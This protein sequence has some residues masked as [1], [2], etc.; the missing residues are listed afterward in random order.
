MDIEFESART[1]YVWHALKATDNERKHGVEFFE[2]VTVF[3][4]PLLVSV[5]ASIEIEVRN[6]AIGFSTDGR[7]LSVVHLEVEGEVIRIISAWRATVVEE[8]LYDR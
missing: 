2:A 7:L 3:T 5:D 6:K 4:D 8:A 1:S